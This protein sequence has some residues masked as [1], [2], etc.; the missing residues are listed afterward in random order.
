MNWSL[1]SMCV[2]QTVDHQQVCIVYKTN[3][4]YL[5][6]IDFYLFFCFVDMYCVL[7]RAIS[8]RTG[9]CRLLFARDMVLLVLD[10]LVMGTHYSMLWN[11]D[12]GW[13]EKEYWKSMV[14]CCL[15]L[16]QLQLPFREI[17]SNY[18]QYS[19]SFYCNLLIRAEIS[20]NKISENK[21]VGH[22]P[23][24]SFQKKFLQYQ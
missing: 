10:L 6:V 23:L 19:K 5:A 8:P 17:F 3:V 11:L 4:A 24:F 16:Q 18:S 14:F 21:V 22:R 7:C 13:N 9:Q 1:E 15:Q 12:A 2:V 20:C